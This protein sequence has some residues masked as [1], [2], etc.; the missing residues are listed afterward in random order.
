MT[1]AYALALGAGTQ[2]FTQ[3]IG[4]AVFG[5]S[6]LTTDLTLGAGWAINLAVAE[7][8][9]RRARQQPNHHGRRA[10]VRL[11]MTHVTRRHGARRLPAPGRRA[12]RPPL[13]CL[14]RRPHPD[15]RSDGTTSL[16]GAVSDQAELHGLLTKIRDLGVTLISVEAI[17][18]TDKKACTGTG[19]TG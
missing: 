15:P 4:N 18:P 2:V 10:E 13:V 1:R 9:I 6:E 12:P 3:G 17:D 5:T 14:V 8:V 19:D 16:S 11:L 7:Y